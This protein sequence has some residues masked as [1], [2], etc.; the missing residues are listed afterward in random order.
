MQIVC[1]HV[2]NY[3]GHCL[4]TP[5]DVPFLSPATMRSLVEFHDAG[6]YAA[7]LL[8][9]EPADPAG[10]GRVVRSASGE[11]ERIVEEGDSTPKQLAIGE[12]NSGVYVFDYRKLV[13]ALK[14]VGRDNRQNELYLTDV[15][16]ILRESGERIGAMKAEDPVEVMGINHPAQLREAERIWREKH[17]MEPARRPRPPIQFTE[18]DEEELGVAVGDAGDEPLAAADLE[19]PDLDEIPETP[20]ESSQEPSGA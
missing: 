10:Y 11:V 17:P 7:T 2:G 5:G 20:V 13:I 6:Q 14:R 8:T 16:G 4:V 12:V 19:D 15:I 3:D 18:D 1:E 9:S